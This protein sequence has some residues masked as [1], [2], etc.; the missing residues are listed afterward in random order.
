MAPATFTQDPTKVSPHDEAARRDYLVAY[1]KTIGLFD[2]EHLERRYSKAVVA[3]S[4]DLH[5]RG[6]RQVGH[7]F[8]EYMVDHIIWDDMFKCATKTGHVVPRFPWDNMPKTNDHSQG[9]STTYK[10]WRLKNGHDVPPDVPVSLPTRPTPHQV[11]RSAP[12]SQEGTVPLPPI[13]FEARAPQV[14]ETFRF[15]TPFKRGNAATNMQADRGK[16]RKGPMDDDTLATSKRTRFSTHPDVGVHNDKGM[17]P[18][19]IA[20]LASRQTMRKNI[21]GDTPFSYPIVGPFE[22]DLPPWLDFD[23][24]IWGKDGKL[25]DELISSLHDFLTVGWTTAGG[26]PSRLVIGFNPSH[27]DTSKRH[28]L[29]YDLTT[30][31]EDVLT[32]FTQARRSSWVALLHSLRGQN[33]RRTFQACNKAQGRLKGVQ[34]ESGRGPVPEEQ[35]ALERHSMEE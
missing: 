35:V 22:I 17:E 25:Y 11:P 4:N 34:W 1:I 5:S 19:P 32:W 14:P 7:L 23:T 2:K 12:S 20:S 33:W 26:K 13:A 10:K 30:L 29:W 21:N 6:A 8:F 9:I 18:A 24:L 3:L 28:R 15:T 16:K 31:W 27:E